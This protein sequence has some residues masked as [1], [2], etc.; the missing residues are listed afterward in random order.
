MKHE[1]QDNSPEM[2]IVHCSAGKDRPTLDVPGIIA[3]HLGLGW[4]DVGYHYLLD[5]VFNRVHILLGRPWWKH[6]A[7]CPQKQRVS[8]GICVVGRYEKKEP[9]AEMMNKLAELCASL[10]REFHIS[11]R[12]IHP[13]Y[14][15]ARDRRTCPGKNFPMGDL[16]VRTAK[17]LVD[18]FGGM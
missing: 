18:V 9:S 1:T 10:C 15:F 17:I 4:S 14:R 12:K 13:H 16:R 5:T 11:I 7:H 2:I 3:H 8:I 6:G